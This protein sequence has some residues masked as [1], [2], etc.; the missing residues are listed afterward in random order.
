MGCTYS[1]HQDEP[2]PRSVP[3]S[4]RETVWMPVGTLTGVWRE[5]APGQGRLE[6]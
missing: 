4:I 3:D 6:A 2:I 5:L 1:A